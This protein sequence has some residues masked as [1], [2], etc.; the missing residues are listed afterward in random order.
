M[1]YFKELDE[2]FLEFIQKRIFARIVNRNKK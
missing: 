1:G 2:L